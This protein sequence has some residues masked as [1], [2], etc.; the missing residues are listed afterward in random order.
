[1]DGDAPRPSADPLAV[2][3]QSTGTQP[4][5]R[6]ADPRDGGLSAAKWRFKD[7]RLTTGSTVGG[8]LSF[9]TSG[10]A[11][12]T[13]RE[14]VE[15]VRKRPAIGSATFAAGDSPVRWTTEGESESLHIYIPQARVQGF[16]ERE[17]AT[18][19][20]PRIHEFFAV[21]DPWLQGYL[22][23]LTSE[24]EIFACVGQPPDSL[25][26]AHTEDV[27]LRHLLRWH[28]Q[29]GARQLEALAS[30]PQNPLRSGIMRRVQEYIDAHLAEDISLQQLADLACMS[31][32]HFLRSFRVA[33]GSTPYQYVL[34]QRLE[35]A[36]A[37]L[38]SCT[39][40]VSRI[41]R[42]CGFKTPSHLSVQFHARFGVSP[43]R[44][45]MTAGARP[46]A[47]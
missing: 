32:G 7:I 45:R 41:A 37:M 18:P 19:S 6:I 36:R 5:Y 17:L 13:R 9:R 14:G 31:P 24:F 22:Q 47:S 23:I 39:E 44:Y 30:R 20:F 10:S 40:P 33:S 29:A 1:M 46:D 2:V 11:A 42:R 26:L 3:A 21:V 25:L 28:S 15:S 27:L 4:L 35:S 16:A 34:E 12:V 8:I 38:V 43:S